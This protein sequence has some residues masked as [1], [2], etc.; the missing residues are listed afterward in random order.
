MYVFDNQAQLQCHISTT[1]V[2]AGFHELVTCDNL[3]D[4]DVIIVTCMYVTVHLPECY[5]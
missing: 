5:L 2:K 4:A 3:V 1:F